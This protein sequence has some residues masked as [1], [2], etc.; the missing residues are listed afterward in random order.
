VEKP[1]Y[2]Y[3]TSYHLKALRRLE[4]GPLTVPDHIFFLSYEAL[5]DLGYCYRELGPDGFT[6]R[7]DDLGKAYLRDTWEAD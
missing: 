1:K 6:V 5:C 3:L 7:L 4:R 2:N